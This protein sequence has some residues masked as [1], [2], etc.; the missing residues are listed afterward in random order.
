MKKGKITA[1][2]IAGILLLSGL[3]CCAVAVNMVQFD[4]TR[5]GTQ[6]AYQKQ[7]Y[8]VSAAGIKEISV[9]DSN[10]EIVI[11]PSSDDK[12]RITYYETEKET[13]LIQEKNGA[14]SVAYSDTRKWYEHIEINWSFQSRKIEV[15]LPE[16]Y[17][18]ALK[19]VTS[20]GSI[21]IENVSVAGALTA[22]T[23]NGRVTLENVTTG[24]DLYIKTSNGGIVTS[25]VSAK[26]DI[27]LK[28]SN[29]GISLDITEVGSKLECDTSNAAVK[30]T[31]PGDM[32]D[33]T[34]IADTSNAKS[35]LPERYEGKGEKRLIIDTS[36]G[37]IQV[38]FQ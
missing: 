16:S 30:G 23:S 9:D 7:Q 17:G 37:A 10:N 6:K 29:G 26:G 3:I 21:R 33:Y 11:L 34:I 19:T 28:T 25:G 24:S 15:E 14:L 12:I 5:L 31:V 27:L 18:G 1:I 2:I 13:Y 8:E 38:D 4:F 22:E 20:N 36:N 35:N 32:T